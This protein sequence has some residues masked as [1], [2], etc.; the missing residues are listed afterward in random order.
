MPI[1][2]LDQEYIPLAEDPDFDWHWSAEEVRTVTKLWRKGIS[3]WKIAEQ[4]DRDA[5]E[6]MVLLIALSRRGIIRPRPGW[7]WGKENK[8]A[9]K[10]S[11][12]DIGK[13]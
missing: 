1:A 3:F 11:Q 9:I 7:V 4:L 2:V 8:N 13:A 12:E 6:V 5:D 10:T